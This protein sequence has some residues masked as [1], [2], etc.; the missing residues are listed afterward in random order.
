MD[1]RTLTRVSLWIAVAVA[2]FNALS[3]IAG[4]AGMMLTDGLGM[5]RSFL[6]NSPFSS[7]LLPALILLVVVGGT[8]AVAF[9]QL[10]RRSWSALLWNAIAGFGMV[11]WIAVELMMIRQFTWLQVLYLATGLLQLA[12]SLGLLGI[13]PWLPRLE[14]R[15]PAVPEPTAR[16]ASAHR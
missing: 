16:R 3:G 11:I 15:T 4:G 7:F 2:G 14:L 13:V 5:P 1:A 8:Q 10:A 12:L 9:V 6:D